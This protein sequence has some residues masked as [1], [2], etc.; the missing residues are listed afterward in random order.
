MPRNLSSETLRSRS[1]FEIVVATSLVGCLEIFDFTVFGLFAGWIGDQFFP[2]AVPMLSLLLAVGTF[3]VGF[4][5]RPLGAMVIGAYADR[6]GRRAALTLTIWLMAASVATIALCPPY[7]TIGIAAPILILVSRLL[8]G[9]AAG[10]EIGAGAAYVM[11]AAPRARRNFLVSWQIVGQAASAIL[12]ALLGALLSSCLSAGDLA[13]WGWRIPFL[14]GLLIVPLGVFVRRR[15]PEDTAPQ[16][17]AT[18]DR[19]QLLELCR[20]HGK[21]LT[22][23]TLMMAG[24]TVPAFAVVYYMP[25]YLTHVLHLPAVI[26][27]LSSA[28]GALVLMLVAPLSGLLADR[29]KQRKPL[30][31]FA[32]GATTLLIY[33]VFH[34]ITHTHSTAAV[35]AG[36]GLIS[37]FV[38][39]C[40]SVGTVLVMESFPARMR[41]TGLAV[42]YALGV[43]IFGGTAQV[44]ITW[45][46]KLASNPMAATWYAGPACFVGFCALL[47]FPEQREDGVSAPRQ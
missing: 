38:A 22:L 10:G 29:L 46:I 23:A 19:L 12:G 24:R 42:S 2:S 30:L 5:F 1:M 25:S 45:L 27:F 14:I 18:R 20:T 16:R 9:L 35:L 33:P 47:F 15:L 44:I 28:V 40:S 6:V 3:G 36:V 11:E 34:L 31:L 39:P 13:A 41:A 7:R 17:A 26:G 21:K 37:V 4:L 43:A 32:Y 8:Q